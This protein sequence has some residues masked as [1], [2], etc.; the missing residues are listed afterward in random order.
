[1]IYRLRLNCNS[2]L[3]MHYEGPGQ[4]SN[5]YYLCAHTHTHTHTHIYNHSKIYTTHTLLS[6]TWTFKNGWLQLEIWKSLLVYTWN[7][8]L[9]A[10]LSVGLQY[11]DCRGCT[12]I[13]S[14]EK[15]IMELVLEM[16]ANNRTI[17]SRCGNDMLCVHAK[18]CVLGVLKITVEWIRLC[19]L[20]ESLIF[21]WWW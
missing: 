3:Y 16:E 8:R 13:Y 21:L 1:M 11:M 12:Y 14:Y 9:C 18:T 10:S 15:N 6:N 17:L 7:I 20:P 19:K 2:S 5:I 4:K